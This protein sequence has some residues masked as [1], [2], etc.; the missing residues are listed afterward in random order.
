MSK[1]PA[2][3]SAVSFANHLNRKKKSVDNYRKQKRNYD[4]RRSL[5]NGQLTFNLT[6][7]AEEGWTIDPR[8]IEHYS[9][10][11]TTKT[12]HSRHSS[13]ARF[14]KLSTNSRSLFLILTFFQ[15]SQSR[16]SHHTYQRTVNPIVSVGK[17][18]LQRLEGKA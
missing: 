2:L 12:T 7:G 6:I 9:Q 16:Q 11:Q 5:R 8:Q 18:R 4:T 1:W 15:R 3:L 13:E 17:W 14:S 10:N